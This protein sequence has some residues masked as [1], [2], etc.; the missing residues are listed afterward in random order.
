MGLSAAFGRAMRGVRA[1]RGISQEALADLC[2][3][4][5]T[6][7]GAV[8]RGEKNISIRNIERIAVALG[9]ASSELLRRAE[10]AM[11]EAQSEARAGPRDRSTIKGLE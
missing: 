4:H 5:R 3:L 7:V 2:G 10:D 6:Y 9:V 1:E 8:E 11:I